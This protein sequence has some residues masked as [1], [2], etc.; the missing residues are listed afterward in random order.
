[1]SRDVLEVFSAAVEIDDTGERAAYLDR[2]CGGDAELLRKVADLLAVH[3]EIDGL[4]GFFDGAGVENSAATDDVGGQVGRYK[5]LEKIGEGGWGT[6][7]R[8]EQT[9]PVRRQVALKIIKLGMDTRQVIARFEAERQAL[10][11]MDHPNIAR[12]FDA[13]ATE[14][15]RPFFVMELVR[16]IRITDYCDRHR[17]TM[18]QRLELFISVCQAVQHAHQKG[19][20]H[21]DLKPSNILVSPEDGKPVPKVIDFGVA[22]ATEDVHL[23]DMTLVTRVGMFIGTPAYMSPEQADFSE[24]GVDTRTDI[25]ALGVLL[26]EL[27]T[28]QTPF[29]S[30][31]LM[32]AGVD[33]MRRTLREQDP[34]KPSTRL[35]Q[36]APDTVA[37]VSGQRQSEHRR[38]VAQVQ[39]DLDWIALRAMEK[40]R[41]R[42]YETANG[43]A[44]D[45]RRF[46]D[47]EPVTARPPSAVYTFSK[48]ARRNR[49][50]FIGSAAVLAALVLGII[51]SAWQ[52][53]R[54]THAEHEQRE[55]RTAADAARNEAF[56]RAYAADMKATSIALAEGNLGQ[57][58]ALLDR[59]LPVKGQPEVRGFE[60]SVLRSRA[61]GDEI[62][63]FDQTGIN[64]GIVIAPDN[65]WVAAAVKY[66]DVTVWDTATGRLLHTF[67]ALKK[68]EPR[69][70]ITLSPDGSLLAYSS[71]DS[72]L[73]RRTD[74]WELQREIPGRAN[75]ILFSPDGR[76]AWGAEDGIHFLAAQTF[77]KDFDLPDIALDG[78]SLLSFTADGSKLG[79]QARR[80]FFDVWDVPTR[81]RLTHIDQSYP[82]AG[83]SPD[84]RLAALGTSN[85]VLV[86]WDL[87]TGKE[88]AKTQAHAS[89]LMDVTF[90]ADSKQLLTA[91]GDQTVRLWDLTAPEPLAKE[92]G[93][94]R[95]HWNEVWNVAFS[96]DGTRIVTGGKDARV[97]LWTA[98]P[99]RP[100]IIDVPIPGDSVHAG[101]FSDGSRFRIKMPD[102]ILFF[103]VTDASP[104]GEWLIPAEFELQHEY[105]SGDRVLMCNRDGRVVMHAL[106]AG[107]RVHEIAC[108]EQPAASVAGFT[109]DGRTLATLRKSSDT[110]D[111]WNFETGAWLCALPGYLHSR[112]TPVYDRVSFSPDGRRIAYTAVDTKVNIFDL[113]SRAVVQALGGFTWH[114]YG[115]AWSPDG[116]A[117]VTSSWDGS[118]IVWNPENGTRAL[119][120]LRGHFAGVRTLTFSADSRTLVTHGGEST[121]RF[122]NLA[123][124]TEVLTLEDADAFWKCP[125]SPDGRTLLWRRSSDSVF[126]LEH[127]SSG[128]MPD[129][130]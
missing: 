98:Q 64:A 2:A 102:R 73:V 24:A 26:Y 70:A 75:V 122:W 31:T 113:P 124:G 114:L 19:I 36:L 13:G 106:P 76:L 89:W 96:R 83:I 47:N 27:L 53:V 43:L 85:G 21:R 29:D 90:S 1:M 115:A 128:P 14:T 86:L 22:K 6:V 116:R 94:W 58:N 54:A 40:D 121:I 123:T 81:T 61:A 87:G 5:L 119:P 105:M 101:F 82:S 77:E 37:T 84:G 44:A 109:R 38:L 52:A 74:N 67:P 88:I 51:V 65:S 95:G 78:S 59:Y 99:P 17:L 100:H 68:R 9:E 80:T 125:I 93:S 60:W 97:K 117:L 112:G 56:T 130:R 35:R 20:I 46:L 127:L 111:L 107:E 120:V 25:Y 66:G 92:A 39:G 42:R 48:W 55:L 50:T 23:T 34:Q 118:V 4:D 126:Q 7:Y 71:D 8:A 45:V 49:A 72:I 57:A 103:T 41:T 62:A 63:S 16:G 69:R 108:T 10:A 28:G 110:I 11:M 33:E 3:E 15:G 129:W 18:A 91:G 12:V 32:K 104:A 30:E 79:V